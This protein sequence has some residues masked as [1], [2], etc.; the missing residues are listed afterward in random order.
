MQAHETLLKL[1]MNLVKCL[2]EMLPR[3]ILRISLKF[4]ESNCS[5]QFLS[6][7]S[8]APVGGIQGQCLLTNQRGPEQSISKPKT[9]NRELIR[10]LTCN[11]DVILTNTYPVQA[12]ARFCLTLSVRFFAMLVF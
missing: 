4:L 8:I 1:Q 2:G 10:C 5:I 9:C 6:Y 7:G 12:T 11:F 3:N